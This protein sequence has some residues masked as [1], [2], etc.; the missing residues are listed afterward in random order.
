VTEQGPAGGQDWTPLILAVAPNGARKTRADHP[1]LPIEPGELAETAASCLAAGACM[2]HL[3]VRD[4]AGGHSLDPGRYREATAAIRERVG[5]AMIVQITTEQVGRFGRADQLAC[6]RAV[7][8]EAVSLALR[9]LVPDAAAEDEAADF[10]AELAEAGML[11]QFILY[12]PADLRRF[13][14]L[15]G[16]GVIPPGQRSLLYVLGRY[17]AGQRSR[18]ADLLPFL[19]VR[20]PAEGEVWSLCAFGPREAA[21]ALAAAALGGHVRVGFENNL[22]LADGSRAPDNA[23]AVAAIARS[24]LAIGRPLADAAQARRLMAAADG[25]AVEGARAPGFAG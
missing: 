10:F 17:S 20:P 25:T 11:V 8:P 3:H 21:C 24:V 15:R 2:I 4:A 22:E 16:A 12:D 9:E 7:R 6:V 13:L 23:A 14:A 18:P 1:A 19:A 5:D